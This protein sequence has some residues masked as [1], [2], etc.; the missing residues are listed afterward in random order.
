M[1]LRIVVVDSNE[2][3]VDSDD[4]TTLSFVKSFNAKV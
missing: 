4:V 1:Q 2:I 3:L